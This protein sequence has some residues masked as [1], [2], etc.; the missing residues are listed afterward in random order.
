MWVK[1]C[2]IGSLESAQAVFAARPDAIGLNFYAQSRRCISPD[3]AREIVRETPAGVM[4]VGVFVNHSEADIRDIC[5][6]AGLGAIQL[7]GDEPPEFAARLQDFRIVRAFRVG[8][9]GLDS[10]AKALE[11][12]AALRMSLFGCLIDAESPGAYGGTGRQAP[13]ELIAGAWRSDW[14]PL[15][16]A[17]G[18]N[19]ANVADA[20]RQTRPFGVDVASGVESAPGRQDPEAVR[21]FIASARA[22]A[23]PG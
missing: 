16:L 19:P 22:A 5:A 7:H 14:P 17:G 21:K 2:G 23:S 18:L 10:V 6:F 11:E 12:Y 3:A 13:W 1:I 9:A 20:I 4:P 8:S 15:I